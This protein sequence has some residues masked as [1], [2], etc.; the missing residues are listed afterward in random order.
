[1]AKHLN[2]T[3]T[4][5]DIWVLNKNSKMILII[6]IS[7]RPVIKDK[8]TLF[9]KNMLSKNLWGKAFIACLNDSMFEQF[10]MCSGNSFLWQLLYLQMSTSPG[11]YEK[12]FALELRGCPLANW[13]FLKWKMLLPNCSTRLCTNL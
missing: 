10:T 13:L 11:Y 4:S 6:I 9:N 3:Y 12:A 7:D 8:K 5:S 1:M 2:V